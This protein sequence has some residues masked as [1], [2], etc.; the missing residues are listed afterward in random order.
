MIP[1]KQKREAADVA[2][3]PAELLDRQFGDEAAMALALGTPAVD[4]APVPRAVWEAAL[5]APARDMLARPGKRFRER[6]V[7]VAWRLAGA[8]G[9]CPPALPMVLEVLH[10]GSLIVDDIED[11][12]R[13]RRG[14]AC[15]HRIYGLPLALNTGN[16]MY[17]WAQELLG[18]MGLPPGIE[19]ELR[20]R[21][22]R[23]V[24][25]C[26]FGQA[27]DLG[28]D[29]GRIAQSTVP[30]VVATSTDL[31]TG[32]LME[33]AAEVG[34]VAAGG[35]SSLATALARFGRKLGVGLQMLDDLGNLAPAEGSGDGV[36]SVEKR[37]EDLRLGRP[38]WPWAWAAQNLDTRAFAALQADARILRAH[39]LAG[40]PADADAL[41]AALR[42]AAGL[43]A[44]RGARALLGKALM[45]L[46]GVLGP[47]PELTLIADEIERLERAYV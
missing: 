11:D 43:E 31:K 30:A 44:R 13:Q 21:V 47:G 24:F 46:D 29:I 4:G 20:R 2:L 22:S 42:S 9:D 37:Y 35:A 26:H 16:W 32:T 1:H 28:A 12:S 34:V 40:Q 36:A 19:A 8:P 25:R 7:G 41:A 38:T 3:G 14:A 10:A 18:Q 45:E 17:F 6:L 5:L 39:S 33:L 23:T 15:L 27:L